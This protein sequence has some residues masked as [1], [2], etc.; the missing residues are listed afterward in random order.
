M[1]TLEQRV[2]IELLAGEISGKAEICE[3][4]L[5]TADWAGVLEEAKAQ[6]V[7]LM[8]AEA[9]VRYREYIPNYR[10][11]EN[12]AAAAHTLNVRTAF[13]EQQLNNIMGDRPF[14]I[15]KGMAAA[16]Y[17]PSQGNAVSAI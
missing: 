14:L 13:E 7:P 10:E 8:A 4:E 1:P 12:I 5:K 15:L 6:A 9:V 11:W 16:S 2:L 3:E 17:Y